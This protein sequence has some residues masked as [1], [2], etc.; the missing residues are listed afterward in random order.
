M[1]VVVVVH[2]DVCLDFGYQQI[3]EA[4]LIVKGTVIFRFN[5]QLVLKEF[6]VFMQRSELLKSNCPLISESDSSSY[7][8]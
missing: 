1:I 8:V 2:D 6:T 5:S 7:N 3:A 4:H